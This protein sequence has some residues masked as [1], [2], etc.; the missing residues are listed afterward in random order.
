MILRNYFFGMLILCFGFTC[1][2]QKTEQ[3]QANWFAYMGQYK[4]SS[5]FGYHVEA[6]FR[7]DG[8]LEFSRQHLFRLGAIY[9]FNNKSNTTAGY[10]LIKTY[11]AAIDG[12]FGENRIWE[13]Y[14]YN[15]SWNNSKNYFINRFRLEQRFVNEKILVNNVIQNNGTNYQNRFRYFN[16][17]LF[18]ILNFNSSNKQLYAVLQDE[19]FFNLGT[20]KVNSNFFD[21]NR[22]LVGLG[23]NYSNNIRFE[24]GYMNQFVNPDNGNAKMNHVIS[25]SLHQNLILY[26]E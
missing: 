20:N 12:Y 13:Q 1:L 22:F 14:Q 11:N 26:K 18:Q 21:Q 5:K 4:V 10:A 8:N 9:Y 16:R 24:L 23:L 17:N 3:N 6:Q 2:A 25:F 19:V 15:H 7:L